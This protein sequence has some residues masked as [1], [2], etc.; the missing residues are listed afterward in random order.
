[1]SR[2]FILLLDSFGLGALPDAD[3]YGD[4]GA[5]TF[6]HIAAWA[7]K[8]GRP[9]SLPNLER[10]GL[11]A[12]AHKA[13]GEWAPGF[14]RRDGFT[15]AWGVAREQSTGKDTQSG[16]WEIAG[17][18]VLFDWGYFPKTVPSFP[19]ALTDRLQE[20]TGVPGWLGNCH[21]SGTTI[22]DELGDEHVA[23][24]KPILYTSA[25]SVLQ[26]AAH[27]AHFGLDRLYAVCE[28][29]YELVKPYNIGRVIA[30]PFLGEKGKYKRTS[31][32][33]DY[34]VPPTA[35]T[36]LD[37]V[38]DEGGEVIALG[39][40]SDIFA[41]Q[42]VTR[43]IKGV[44]N[45]ALFDRLLEVADEAPEKSL[46]FVNF[47]DFDMHFGHRRDVAGYSNALHELDARLPEFM[48]RLKDG[49]L[50][51][52]TADHGCDPTAPGSD[53]TREHIPMIFFGPN[54]AP[55]ELPIAPT[56][57]DIGATLAKH[58]GVKPLSNGTALL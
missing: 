43:L 41:A 50:V 13:C 9:M 19:Q 31:N 23:S 39:K 30:R 18:P 37:H 22:I 34:A 56:F 53:H 49:D 21:A 2:A 5:N 4:T 35:P 10:L 17:V 32:R 25:D 27:E 55:R 51:V 14:D 38:A 3:Q 47:V 16:H 57:S 42:G 6:G 33:H 54:V 24:G 44:D 36:L 29:A 52:I 48:A 12:A 58:L 45:M 15:G 46:S 20:L 8:E 11:A 1:M 26:I 40:I 28:A 7:A